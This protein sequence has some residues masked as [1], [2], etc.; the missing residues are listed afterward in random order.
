MPPPYTLNQ[1]PFPAKR[2]ERGGNRGSRGKVSAVDL[3]KAPMTPAPPVRPPA[4]MTPAPVGLPAPN[5]SPYAGATAGGM[6][7]PRPNVGAFRGRGAALQPSQ[8]GGFIHPRA[9]LPQSTLPPAGTSR[10]PLMPPPSTGISERPLTAEAGRLQGMADAYAAGS[11]PPQGLQ[12]PGMP[13]Q[14]M[15]QQSAMQAPMMDMGMMGGGGGFGPFGSKEQ[16][17]AQFAAEHGGRMP[18]Q[19]DEMDALASFDYLA[20]TGAPPTERDWLRRYYTGYW[21]GGVQEAGGSIYNSK[22]APSVMPGMMGGGAPTFAGVLP[23]GAGML[24]SMDWV[25]GGF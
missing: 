25:L 19:T 4:G 7:T 2:P 6:V 13:L 20:Q 23:P 24:P 15:M 9:V 12:H 18:D 11:M 21:P 1:P 8:P 3:L 22:F 14:S 17:A 10:V 16:W 5:L